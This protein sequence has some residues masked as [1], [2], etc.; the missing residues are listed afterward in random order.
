MQLDLVKVSD[1]SFIYSRIV[2]NKIKQ[3]IAHNE[4]DI[5]TS[6]NNIVL[7]N[8]DTYYMYMSRIDIFIAAWKMTSCISN[9]IHV[10]YNMLTYMY[11]RLPEY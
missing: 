10:V 7:H 1:F 4:T 9:I 5:I 8:K 11:I 2:N 6:N 3:D